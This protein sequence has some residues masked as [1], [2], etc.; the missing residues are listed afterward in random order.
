MENEIRDYMYK[1]STF[2]I[3]GEVLMTA[4]RLGILD[5]IQPTDLRGTAPLVSLK[6]LYEDNL[7]K[8]LGIDGMFKRLVQEAQIGIKPKK[9]ATQ[10][11]EHDHD[12]NAGLNLAVLKQQDWAAASKRDTLVMIIWKR[13]KWMCYYL[14]D[15]RGFDILTFSTIITSSIFLCLEPPHP[16]MPSALT[17]ETLR[18]WDMVFNFIFVLEAVSKIGAY[19]LYIPSSIHHPSYLQVTQ[20]RLDALVLTLALIEMSGGSIVLKYI[21]AGTMKMIRLMKVICFPN[22]TC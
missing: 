22:L 14:V 9:A 18:L 5:K 19:G 20:N 13:Y 7:G 1:L 8:R 2:G 6:L 10:T 11:T 3:L 12:D 15:N 16:S 17:Y 4:T 21:G